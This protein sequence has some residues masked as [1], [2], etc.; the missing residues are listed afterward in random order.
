MLK[1]PLAVKDPD[2]SN[3]GSRVRYLARGSIA[4]Q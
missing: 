1:G 4:N 2:V 3:K